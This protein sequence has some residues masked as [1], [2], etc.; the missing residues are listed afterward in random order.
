MNALR[1]VQSLWFVLRN[2]SRKNTTKRKKLT[3]KLKIMKFL[4]E[5]FKNDEADSKEGTQILIH[6]TKFIQINTYYWT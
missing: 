5:G 6:R 3:N 1:N 4:L 2:L